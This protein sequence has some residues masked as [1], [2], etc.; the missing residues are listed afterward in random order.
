ML[1][2]TGLTLALAAAPAFAGKTSRQV[3]SLERR[4]AATSDNSTS[5]SNATIVVQPNLSI[6]N[7]LPFPFDRI[8][9]NNATIS[10]V[11]LPSAASYEY[12]GQ[13]SVAEAQ[14]E[15][16][17]V[18]NATVVAWQ[19]E[20]SQ[21]AGNITLERVF[22][23]GNFHEAPVYIPLTNQIFLTPDNGT[24]Q[25]LIDLNTT[26]LSNFTASPPIENINGGTFHSGLIYVTTNGGNETNPAVF[27]IDP[28]TNQSSIVVDNYCG[29]RFNSLNDIVADSQ[30]NLWFN[31]PTYGYLN[32]FNPNPPQLLPATYLYNSTSRIV[33]AVI[34]DIKEPNG[35]AFSPDQ[36]LVYVSDTGASQS[37]SSP[38]LA[39]PRVIYAF[40][41]L[42][43]TFA[44]N[45][46]VFHR[47]PSGIPDGVKVDSAGRVW[48][49]F[50][51]ADTG[52]IEVINP[53]GQ[54][55]GLI[56]L[57]V[58]AQATNLIFV[59]SANETAA[60]D[61]LWLVGGDSIWR[62]SGLNVTGVRLE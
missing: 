7:A 41:V 51:D 26:T 38:P 61:D 13:P 56:Q 2:S 49:V 28:T 39:G 58:D 14:A 32:G 19:E 62:I 47:N 60:G 3:V 6:L 30:G 59:P 15:L 29:L 1:V 36:S 33:K 46:R 40:D 18:A 27:S 9:A 17:K 35:I 52:A 11:T 24:S 44:A 45:R 43:G 12:A 21:I 34:D 8:G 53:D 22:T 42:N 48:S 20:F 5:S 10:N 23:G 31:D 50:G 54:L 16:D 57:P 4:Q 37:S 55:L 25:F